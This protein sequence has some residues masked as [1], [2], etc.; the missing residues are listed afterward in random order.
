M[1]AQATSSKSESAR[2]RVYMA[3]FTNYKKHATS[4]IAIRIG[5]LIQGTYAV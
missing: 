3:Q 2:P 1:D 4:D 5:N